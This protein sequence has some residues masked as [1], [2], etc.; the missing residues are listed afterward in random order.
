MD[1]ERALQAIEREHQQLELE[2]A[3]MEFSQRAPPAPIAHKT[4]KVPGQKKLKPE[5]PAQDE[6]EALVSSSC[7]TA[8]LH[9]R[10]WTLWTRALVLLNPATKSALRSPVAIRR[11]TRNAL[12]APQQ[13]PKPVGGH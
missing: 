11:V 3:M 1:R 8:R 7:I 10:L 12:Y 9:T 13:H 2:I 4:P 6:E 5:R